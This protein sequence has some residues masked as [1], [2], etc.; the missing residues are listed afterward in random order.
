[1]RKKGRYLGVTRSS[2]P[3]PFPAAPRPHRHGGAACPPGDTEPRCSRPRPSPRFHFRSILT[4]SLW[5]LILYFFFFF[6]SKNFRL[7]RR[8]KATHSPQRRSPAQPGWHM[9]AEGPG[10]G[11]GHGAGQRGASAAP[12]SR[13]PHRAADPRATEPHNPQSRWP[14]RAIDPIEPQ[15]PQSHRSYRATEPLILEPQSPRSY[16]AT[17]PTEPLIP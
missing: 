15:S 6:L 11:E 12:Q 7:E 9:A 4:V 2:I 13:W 10:G 3:F 5:F 14:H 16:R 1:M 8:G 17:D